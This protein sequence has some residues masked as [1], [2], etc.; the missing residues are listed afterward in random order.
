MFCAKCQSENPELNQFCGMCGTRL[1]DSS[2]E[3]AISNAV[4]SIPSS[5]VQPIPTMWGSTG[6]G[7]STGMNSPSEIASISERRLTVMKTGEEGEREEWA[8][9][10]Q[11]QL[12]QIV[13]A[14]RPKW[15]SNAPASG[16]ILGLTSPVGEATGESPPHVY[17]EGRERTYPIGDEEDVA[18]QRGPGSSLRFDER[19]HT[20]HDTLRAQL[21]EPEEYAGKDVPRPSFLGLGA[22]DDP[23]YL[24]E[25]GET[26]SHTR[27][28]LLLL[29]SAV[30]ALLSVMEWRATS[31]GESTNPMD[32]LHLRIP[33]KK[34][35]G[36]V[37]VAPTRASSSDA[38]MANNTST[39]SN[40]GKPAETAATAAKPETTS[41]LPKKPEPAGE[42]SPDTM[43]PA[44]GADVS[45]SAGSFE[46]RKGV[47][48]GATA[49]GRTWLWRAMSKDNG[50]APVVLADMYAQGNGVTKDCEQAVLLLRAASKNAN[51][52]ARS[53]MGSMYATGQCVPRDRV[54]AYRWMHSAL[55]VNP[56]SEWLEKNQET[57]W[58]E[59]SAGERQRAA[60]Y[61]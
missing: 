16:S 29:V 14:Y 34:G 46:L 13:E 1:N 48:A 12:E 30:V 17:V 58:K 23:E 49:E 15:A 33:K 40:N 39:G 45:L 55:Q 51:P 22:N 52:H 59:M 4:Q 50:E 19:L 61:R 37:V 35:Q 28:Y 2:A 41:S 31:N 18:A 20:S 53:K 57:L 47:Q 27:R 7:S 3:T 24:L 43:T 36:E 25:E 54:E 8:R 26:H 44:T 11:E 9:Q 42:K 10:T 56:G 6:E 32:V 21:G 60:A 38:T 5:D